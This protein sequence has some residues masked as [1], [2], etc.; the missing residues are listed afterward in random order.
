[1]NEMKSHYFKQAPI[2]CLFVVKNKQF[3]C[4]GRHERNFCG[5]TRVCLGVSI[6]CRRRPQLP[7]PTA[8]MMMIYMCS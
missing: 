2:I 6:E 4:F 1:M 8:Y 7:L 3:I 5:V